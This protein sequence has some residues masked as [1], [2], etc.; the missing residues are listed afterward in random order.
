MNQS[1]G[2]AMME[3]LSPNRCLTTTC[4]KAIAAIYGKSSARISVQF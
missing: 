4:T 3:G 1:Q 2:G